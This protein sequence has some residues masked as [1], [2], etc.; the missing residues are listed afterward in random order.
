M[1]AQQILRV[2]VATLFLCVPSVR[3]QQQQQQQQTPPDDSQPAAPVAP[4]PPLPPQQDDTSDSRQAPA[5]AARGLFISDS[6]DQG[7]GPAEP[8]NHALSSDET[9]GLGSLHAESRIF[10]PVFRFSESVD[11]GVAAGQTTSDTN[12]GG[13]VLFGQL[14]DRYH[15]TVSYNFMQT[16]YEPASNLDEAYQSLNVSEVVM[17]SRW[18]LRLRDALALSP[19]STFGGLFAGGVG[20][21]EQN[22]T[23]TGI[24]PAVQTNETILTGF[25]NRLD[26][27]SVA[28]VDYSLSPRV[29]VTFAG[30]Y[31]LLHFLNP[32]YFDTRN[33]DGRVGF[34]YALDAKD[35]IAIIY[36]YNRTSFTGGASGILES[37]LTQLAFGRKITGRLA[38]QVSAGPQLIRLLDSG[39]SNSTTLSWGLTTSLR[40]QLTRATYLGASYFHG[41]TPGSGVYAGSESDFVTFN[42]G[43]Q[44]SRLLAASLTGGYS[45]N[46]TLAVTAL[47]P[48]TASNYQN[49]YI[50]GSVS[51]QIARG[52]HIGAN[53]G[54]QQQ[55]SAVGVC[56]VLACGLPEGSQ[57][58]ATVTVEW[59]PLAIGNQ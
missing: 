48:N 37:Q 56:P 29:T 31:E 1:K 46:K 55:Y 39:V 22:S 7:T 9:I 23:L 32:G 3:A 13:S 43:H 25:A 36:D 19:E 59:H 42:A 5:P 17:W 26:N 38:L 34:N 24:T 40:Y 11:T 30:S 35:T 28:E 14:R 41:T 2:L 50:G 12:V 57:Q 51:R 49:W 16:F 6:Q 18:T 47:L 8:D 53:Y 15:L 4:V 54:F 58:I 45:L 10:D 21:A 52:L 20:L 44:F 33:W 27:T